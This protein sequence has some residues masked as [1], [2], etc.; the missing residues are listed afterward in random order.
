MSQ[1]QPW[2]PWPPED[3]RVYKERTPENLLR[4]AEQFHVDA[5]VRYRPW[6]GRTYCNIFIWDV[7]RAL[8]CELPHWVT[9]DGKAAPPFGP[10]SREQ[11]AN[12][13]HR[14]LRLYGGLEGWR[15]VAEQDEAEMRADLGYPTVATWYNTQ[16]SGHIALLLTRGRIIQA[17]RNNGI[18]LLKQGFGS[19]KPDFYTHD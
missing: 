8:G 2:L 13:L 11:T 16:G 19:H 14:W 12:D 15:F 17:G 7:S 6:L 5:H 3:M 9:P 10:G 4:A 1:I 18:M